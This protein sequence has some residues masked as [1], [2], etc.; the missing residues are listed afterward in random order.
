[1]VTTQTRQMSF[2]DIKPKRKV[3]YEQILDRLLTGKKT[4]KLPS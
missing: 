2:E 4:A 1:M 3:R